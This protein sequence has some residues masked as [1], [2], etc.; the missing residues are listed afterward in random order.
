MHLY[1]SKVKKKIFLS[2]AEELVNGQHPIIPISKSKA[3]PIVK[4]MA[5]NG[6]SLELKYYSLARLSKFNSFN[7]YDVTHA[8]P[9]VAYDAEISEKEGDYY[10]KVNMQSREILKRNFHAKGIKNIGFEGLEKKKLTDFYFASQLANDIGNDSN[11]ESD[12]LR[13]F[14][15]L[16]SSQKIQNKMKALKQSMDYYVPCAALCLVEKEKYAFSTLDELRDLE[17]GNDFSQI[18]KSYF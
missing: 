7:Q 16:W 11:V 14:P 15:K 9:L 13:M 10:V 8:Y 3:L 6:N 4:E 2:G 1:S 5:I 18:F 12:E 17:D